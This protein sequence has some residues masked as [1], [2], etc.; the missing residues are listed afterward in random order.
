MAP[1][2]AGSS[3]ACCAK[4]AIA[5]ES[6]GFFDARSLAM[7]RQCNRQLRRPASQQNPQNKQNPQF[8]TSFFL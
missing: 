2:G 5:V 1:Q 8:R 3:P 6:Q 7:F 4:V